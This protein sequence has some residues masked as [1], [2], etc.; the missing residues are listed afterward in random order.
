[1]KNVA[2]SVSLPA[3]TGG[4][5]ARDSLAEMGATDAVTLTNFFPATTEL[6]V[7]NGYSVWATGL[8]S[9]VETLMDYESGTASKLFAISGAAI[10]DVT[11]GGA[12]GAAVVS[13]LSNARWQYCN[14]TTSGGSYLYC[15]NGIDAPR[16]YDGATW[17]AI[18]GVSVPAITAVTTTTL[19]SPI[20]FKNRV[21][22]IQAN[23]LKTWYLPTS[24]VGGAAAAVDVSAVAQMGGYI[25]AHA[26]WT[27]DAG[28]GVDDFYVMVT[29]MGEVIVYQGTDPS[30]STTWALKGV[31]RLGTPV[32]S[33][34]L[35]KYAGDVLYISQDGLVPLSG[36]LQSS[37]VNPRV[38][39]TD[40]IQF[41]V[42]EAVS[43]YGST[44][45]WQVLYFAKEN[46]LWLNVPV[47][48][49][50]QQQYVMNAVTKSWANYTG[51]AANCWEI[52]GNNPYF[53]GNTVV[54]KAWDTNA[55]NATN[56]NAF[57][58]QAFSH[59]GAPSRLKRFTM[60]RPVLRV[61]GT[62]AIY[63]NIN[64]DF[65]TS[66]STSPLSYTGS[67]YSA[68]DTGL[69]DTALWGGTLAILQ[70]WQGVNGVGYY[71]APQ[72]NLA[73]KNIDVHWVATDV[74]FE[75]GSY[76]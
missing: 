71:A 37:R 31:W 40:K 3:P 49:G 66:Q 44:F 19:T 47:S 72:L 70:N 39:L 73:S 29:S 67:T 28:T 25:V 55:D 14:I 20:V 65:E 57:G 58:L 17:T 43:L 75:Y 33:R 4:W 41:A 23:T 63:G 18:T 1:M 76:L 32:G 16:L 48:A 74:L 30:S 38:A 60:M 51:W 27:I 50:S 35:Y 59:L 24:A 46:Q 45:G 56:I 53:G 54:C 9:Q 8:P 2:K 13:G 42:S 22:F 5:N 69:W 26:T 6:Y 64:L 34:C 68:W 11:S 52:F 62:P 15:A 61:T 12:V 21:Y 7:R 36:A 10:Y